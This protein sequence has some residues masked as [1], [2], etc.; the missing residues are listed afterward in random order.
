[1]QTPTKLTFVK[2]NQVSLADHA[3]YDEAWLERL[4]KADPSLFGLGP[5]EVVSSQIHQTKGRLDLLLRDEKNQTVYVVELMLGALDESHIV[6]AV[7]YW[8]REKSRKAH[9]EYELVSVLA[10][11]RVLESRFVE[12][13]R[14]LSQQMP[15]VLME[16]SALQLEDRLTLKFTRVFDGREAETESVSATAE[17]TRDSWIEA[18]SQESVGLAER[19][20][21]LL[22]E[23]DPGLSL[24]FKQNF[25]GLRLGNRPNNFFYFNPKRRFLR[26]H[27]RT[28]K[29][30]DFAAKLREAG[31]DDQL[32]SDDS[33][34][35]FR[36]TSPLFEQHRSLLKQ[37][38]EA[39]YSESS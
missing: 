18:T 10:A 21:E 25:L 5:L 28:T 9:D 3:D 15:L 20:V 37:L 39:C 19:I 11:E 35:S 4:I 29:A 16:I 14:F 38:A 6:R 34:V 2:S 24:T 23:I 17:A 22:K 36:L 8:L 12:V 27:A 33:W 30:G 26:V 13:V 7:E 32:T 31:V 1:M